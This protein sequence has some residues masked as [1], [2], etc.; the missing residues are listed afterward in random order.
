MKHRLSSRERLLATMRHE[1]PDHV[2]LF[3]LWWPDSQLVSFN[4]TSERV[5][6]VLD[7]GLDDTLRLEVPHRLPSSVRH[8]LLSELDYPAYGS[9]SRGLENV[10]ARV[11]RE[12]TE[13]TAYPLVHKEYVTPAGRLHQSIRESEYWTTGLDVPLAGGFA[14]L[15]VSGGVE[16]I[17]KGAEDVDRLR[18]LF[19]PP[20]RRQLDAFRDRAAQLKN[21]ADRRG[22]LVEGGWVEWGDA[23]LWLLGVEGLIFAQVDNPGFLE[24]LLEMTWEYEQERISILLD[25]GVDTIVHRGWYHETDFWTPQHYRR[26]L[27]PLLKKEIDMVHQGGALYTYITTK[28]FAHRYQDLL[29]LGV[30][31]LWGIDTMDPTTNLGELKERIGDRIC[32]WGGMNSHLTLGMGTEKEI[33]E[34]VRDAVS[35]LAPGGGFV[36]FPVDQI[37]KDIP[38]ENLQ[39]LIDEWRK[40][41]E[42]PI[43]GG[44]S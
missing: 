17:A 23:M 36:L 39:I 9:D 22:V 6:K 42:Y 29:D 43:A 1:E 37:P 28:G 12:T 11:W 27:K 4:S 2:P 10:T 44:V 13:N 19:Q 14:D 26:F 8:D 40:V 34:A 16:F 5:E 15:N 20:S 21:L 24:Q 32:L 31:S 7:L 38:L 33:R 41:R 35:A 18:Y 30:D 3:N 25:T